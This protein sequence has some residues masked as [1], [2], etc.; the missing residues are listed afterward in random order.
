MCYQFRWIF[1]ITSLTRKSQPSSGVA[2]NYR[3]S[4]QKKGKTHTHTSSKIISL[5]ARILLSIFYTKNLI[6]TAALQMARCAGGG[7]N[8][9]NHQSGR[10]AAALAERRVDAEAGPDAV[11]ARPRG[12]ASRHWH[13]LGAAAAARPRPRPRELPSS[14]NCNQEN[15]QFQPV[16]FTAIKTEQSDLALLV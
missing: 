16:S 3:Q 13:R 7:S 5:V 6:S 2:R 10:G 11:P 8:K 9:G 1:K 14:S 15:V 12:A 4:S